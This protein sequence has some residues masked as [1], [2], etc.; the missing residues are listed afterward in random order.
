MLWKEGQ[1]GRCAPEVL[2][3]TTWYLVTP[4]FGL[5]KRQ[6]NYDLRVEHFKFAK[7]ENSRTYVTFADSN[8][9]QT[10]K[11][12]IKLQRRMAIPRMV[13]TGGERCPVSI[14]EE[15]ISRRPTEFKESSPLYLAINYK[16]K[17]KIWYKAQRISQGNIGKI[18]QSIV[19]GT[20]VEES[21]KRVTGHMPHKTSCQKAGSTW[22]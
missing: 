19:K 6:E 14:F 22:I 16:P 18:M 8:P 21:N 2:L 1:L 3:N 7:D 5:R 4:H 10:R 13:A 20:S 9:T 17:S 11:S 15:F 12:S